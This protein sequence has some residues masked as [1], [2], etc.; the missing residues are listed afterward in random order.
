LPLLTPSEL[1]ELELA[2]LLERDFGARW[3]Y[4]P[5]TGDDLGER[6]LAARFPAPELVAA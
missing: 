2:V 3:V 1:R 6:S 4:G 5:Q